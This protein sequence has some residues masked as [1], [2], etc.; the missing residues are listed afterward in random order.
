MRNGRN[1]R[2]QD[3][4]KTLKTL[5]QLIRES[6]DDTDAMV[7]IIA[8]RVEDYIDNNGDPSIVTDT[9]ELMPLVYID[10]EKLLNLKAAIIDE[11]QYESERDLTEDEKEMVTGFLQLLRG[12]LDP[13][14]VN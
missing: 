2:Q 10:P 9:V 4:R 5:I 3:A 6:I 12:E 13:H 11:I 14:S 7:P 1:N 8:S